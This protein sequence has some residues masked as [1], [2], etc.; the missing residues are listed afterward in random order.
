M[1][2]WLSDFCSALTTQRPEQ[3]KFISDIYTE[4]ANFVVAWQFFF[5]YVYAYLDNFYFQFNSD[6]K[7]HFWIVWL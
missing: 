3:H 6:F 7:I 1:F 2:G 4:S 5:L